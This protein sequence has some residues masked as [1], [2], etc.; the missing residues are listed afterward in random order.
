MNTLLTWLFDHAT[1]IGLTLWM[2][3][4]IATAAHALLTRRDPRAA[5]G[6]IAVCWLFPFAGP[7]LY[8]LFG[9]DRIRTR[10][11]R[12]GLKTVGSPSPAPIEHP[13][14]V[15]RFADGGSHAIPLWLEQVVRTADTLSKLPLLGGNQVRALFDGEQA[16]PAMLAAIHAAREWI[17]LDTYIFDNDFV[18]RAFVTALGDARQ[19]GVDVRVMLD[20]VGRHYSLFPITR[21]LRKRGIDVAIFNPLRLLPPALH[22]NLRNHRKLLIV[23]GRIG[24][25]GGMNI[26]ARHLTQNPQ[27]RAPASDVHFELRGTILEQLAAAF[28]EDW[29]ACCPR[30]WQP[31]VLAATPPGEAPMGAVCRALIGGPNQ[32]HDRIARVLQAAISAASR[33]V[34]VMTPYFL[35]PA[36]M[37]AELQAAALRGVR[38][39]IILPARNNL[40]FVH[41]ASRH[42]LEDLLHYGVHIHEQPP[43]FSHSKLLVVDGVYCQIGSTNLDPRSL[44]LNF[45]LNVEV[46]DRALAQ[47]L[48]AHF[49]Q[50]LSRARE[51]SIAELQTRSLPTRLRDALFWLF[52]PYL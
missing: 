17:I 7:L 27:V 11:R 51:I 12:M 48:A 31:P 50:V 5:W 33:E 18:G 20:G 32:D 40:P 22:I 16:Y 34:M 19:R 35:P 39:D 2:A 43:P 8:F 9:I 47:T 52:S 23:D 1:H 42:A 44:K 3:I 6:W 36:E 49:N 26:G 13:F 14:D 38:V 46:Y 10:A 4:G 21:R 25:T 28:A 30:P 15:R 37:L 45:E 41:W 29:R 24:F